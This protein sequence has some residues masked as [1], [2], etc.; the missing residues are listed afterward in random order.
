MFPSLNHCIIDDFKC[1]YE[2]SDDTFLL[3]DALAS[4]RD[5]IFRSQPRVAVEIGYIIDKSKFDIKK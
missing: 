1:V 3:C 5:D 2:P 4:D